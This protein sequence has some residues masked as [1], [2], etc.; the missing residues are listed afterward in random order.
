MKT[1]LLRI[2]RRWAL[3]GLLLTATLIMGA[4]TTVS[5]AESLAPARV[6]GDFASAIVLDVNTGM[7]LEA[8]REH[9]RRPPA[10]MLKMMTEL[11][12]LER[13]EAGV[14][15]LDDIVTV[16]GNAAKVGGSQVYLKDGEQF[17]V[18]DLLMALA[19]HSA[20]DAATALAEHV[21][22]ST[23]A[24]VELM[25][26]KARDLNMNNTE[27]NSV[28]GLPPARGQR[29]DISTAYDMTLLARELLKHPE[30][31]EWGSMAE[32]PFRG[33]Q[34]TLH[35]PNRLIGKFRGLDGL[36]TGYTKPAGF[37]VTATAEQ[38]GQRLLSVVMGC[39]TNNAR[40][41]ETTRLLTMA[42][43]MF[44]PVKI[45]DG[46]GDAL[47][48][49]LAV[50]DGKV[51]EVQVTYGEAL[52]V[53][54]PRGRRADLVIEREI[55]EQATAPLAAGAEVGRALVKLGDRLL[56]SVPIITMQ[57][58]PRGSWFHRLVH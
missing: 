10:S 50:K 20:N 31:T 12:V 51:R 30:S 35:N 21:A 44:E 32:A 1:E 40:A 46:P 58:A 47:P 22:G 27:F 53:S 43:N 36:K 6:T 34:F 39:S 57:E 16:S 24:F 5:A 33:G 45:I 7:I 49:M 18:R 55:T 11:V 14:L 37:C 23:A 26:A 2:S 25:N 15:T 9:E 19:I 52:T 48:Q 38:N 3:L 56:G 4:A 17:T 42:F 13:I 41:S 28:H 8:Y 29:S 54:V